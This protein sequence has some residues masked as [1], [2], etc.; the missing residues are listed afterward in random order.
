[1]GKAAGAGMKTGFEA[2]DRERVSLQLPV[3]ALC[4]QAGISAST[5]Y[6]GLNGVKVSR[7]DTLGRLNLALKRFKLARGG[8]PGPLSV[9]ASYRFA[10]V[11]AAFELRAD[12]KAVLF[13]DPARRATADE[14]WLA[15]SRVRELAFWTLNGMGGVKVSDVARAAGVTKQTV[16]KAIQRVEDN[17][18][19][20]LKRIC[21][22]LEEVFW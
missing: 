6:D 15:A 5:W 10:L 20:N 9:H 17:D 19:P 12:A 21:K 8:D 2:I 13:S 7:A 22:K 18:D 16:S 4:V 1:A 3:R 11:L 14:E